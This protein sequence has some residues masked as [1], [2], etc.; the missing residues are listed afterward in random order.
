MVV[1]VCRLLRVMMLDLLALFLCC[2]CHRFTLLIEFVLLA[3]LAGFQ[4]LGLF[5]VYAIQFEDAL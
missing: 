4:V 5:L 2:D 3:V 1:I